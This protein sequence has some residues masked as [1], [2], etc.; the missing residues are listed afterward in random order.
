MIGAQEKLVAGRRQHN[1]KGVQ[2]RIIDGHEFSERRQQEHDDDDAEPEGAKRL[3]AGELGNDLRPG[4]FLYQ[5][6]EFGFGV[7]FGDGAQCFFLVNE[8]ADGGC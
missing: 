6:L 1:L 2:F 3:P 4:F 7:D 5:P 8:I